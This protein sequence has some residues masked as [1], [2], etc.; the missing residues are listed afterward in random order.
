MT[1][2]KETGSIAEANIEFLF[3][4][5]LIISLPMLLQGC[6]KMFAIAILW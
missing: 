5:D 1:I 6:E 3:L 2:T 4:I